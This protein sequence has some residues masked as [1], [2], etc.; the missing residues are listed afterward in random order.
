[1]R[2]K[3]QF[4]DKKHIQI[5]N[6]CKET[7]KMSCL[8]PGTIFENRHDA[9]LIESNSLFLPIAASF[10]GVGEGTLT[11]QSETR[12]ERERESCP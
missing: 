8:T 5:E 6:I 9:D 7:N 12:R 11:K 2:S 4:R 3:G 1:M 10:P